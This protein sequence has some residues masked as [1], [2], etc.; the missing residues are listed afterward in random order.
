[1]PTSVFIDHDSVL[2][3]KQI[4][5]VGRKP[6][7]KNVYIRKYAHNK[8]MEVKLILFTKADKCFND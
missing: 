2:I 8:A 1:M 7:L 3:D 5:T 4:I 6:I